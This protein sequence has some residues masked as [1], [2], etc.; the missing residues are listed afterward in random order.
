MKVIVEIS[1]TE[2]NTMGIKKAIAAGWFTIW[3]PERIKGAF[4]FGHGTMEDFKRYKKNNAC[5]CII[6]EYD[7]D[8]LANMTPYYNN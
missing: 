8:E 7:A 1:K 4:N 6:K 5:N 3:T 2:V